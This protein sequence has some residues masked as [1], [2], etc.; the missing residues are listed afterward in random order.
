MVYEDEWQKEFDQWE[1]HM[2]EIDK[3]IGQD[4]QDQLGAYDQQYGNS[5]IPN[6]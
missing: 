6:N 4:I 1:K 3:Q 2:D 5:K